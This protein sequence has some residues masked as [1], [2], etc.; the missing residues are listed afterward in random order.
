MI[1]EDI[2]RN[3]VAAENDRRADLLALAAHLLVLYEAGEIDLAVAM[4]ELID[5]F[6]AILGSAPNPCPVC[7]DPPCRHDAAWCE[8]CREGEA[9][10]RAERARPKP[11]APTPQMTIEAVMYDVRT[12]GPIALKDPANIERLSRCDGQ[13]RTEINDRIAALS[14]RKGAA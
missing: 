9:R 11:P 7:G 5:P 13:A 6:L 8:A 4:D 10:R 14:A 12:R 1:A 3:N 2:L